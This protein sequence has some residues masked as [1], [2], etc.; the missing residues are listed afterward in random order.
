M[1][2]HIVARA[3]ASFEAAVV[4][5]EAGEHQRASMKM[6]F[7]GGAS[8]LL[9]AI[10][11]MLEPGEDATAADLANMDALEAELREF[12]QFPPRGARTN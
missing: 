1:A 12:A 6:A 8:S 3:W 11:N 2:Q 4:P 9:A 7:Y 10:L 5:A